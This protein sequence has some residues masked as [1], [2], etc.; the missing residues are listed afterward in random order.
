MT[1]HLIDRFSRVSKNF[2]Q[3]IGQLSAI[4]LYDVRCSVL[5]APIEQVKS[6]WPRRHRLWSILSGCVRDTEGFGETE[7]GQK[8]LKVWSF[9][10]KGVRLPNEAL[11]V[12]NICSCILI[13]IFCSLL[14]IF[15]SFFSAPGD[16]GNT[17]SILGGRRITWCY[18]NMEHASREYHHDSALRA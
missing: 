8:W 15:P 18:P 16:I 6:W 14:W 9:I 17:L 1:A 7:T 11:C 12:V 5:C 2:T 3:M 10:N 4:F 13:F